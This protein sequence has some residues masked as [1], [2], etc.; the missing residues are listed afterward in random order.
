MSSFHDGSQHD[1]KI[2]MMK[3]GGNGWK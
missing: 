3:W 1:R 2:W